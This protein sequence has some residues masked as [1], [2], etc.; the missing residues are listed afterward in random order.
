M[1]LVNIVAI[2]CCRS[3]QALSLSYSPAAS[4]ARMVLNAIGLEIMALYPGACSTMSAFQQQQDIGREQRWC[5]A[6]PAA[7]RMR[8]SAAA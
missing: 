1:A 8:V 7:P 6:A 2:S 3:S 5:T 4:F